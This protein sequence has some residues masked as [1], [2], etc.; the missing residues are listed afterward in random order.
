MPDGNPAQGPTRIRSMAP[1]APAASSVERYRGTLASFA[2]SSGERF[3]VAAWDESPLGAWGS[4]LVAENDGTR[5]L[6]ATSARSADAVRE[7]HDIDKVVLADVTIDRSRHSEWSVG[8]RS[9]D[10]GH[11]SFVLRRGRPTVRGAVVAL[12]PRTITETRAFA[13]FTE[14]MLRVLGIVVPGFRTVHTAGRLRD[15]RREYHC[16]RTEHAITSVEG[17]FAG[18]RMGPLAPV[19]PCGFGFS[20]PPRRPTIG[21]MTALRFASSET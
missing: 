20:D 17:L 14:G 15:G 19:G 2:V 3:V 8:V 11:T 4:V 1:I 16:A 18:R 5:T 7:L 21:A 9:D 13:T 10:A 12:I 6:F